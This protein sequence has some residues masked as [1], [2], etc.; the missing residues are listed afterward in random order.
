M[1]YC[2]AD[3]KTKQNKTKTKNKKQTKKKNQTGIGNDGA[4]LTAIL[5]FQKRGLQKFTTK[6]LRGQPK[7]R[8][9]ERKKKKNSHMRAIFHSI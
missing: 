1:E 7:E 4:I 5:H 8:K 6:F 3:K 2:G 9:K